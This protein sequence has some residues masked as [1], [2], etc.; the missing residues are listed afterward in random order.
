VGDN[1]KSRKKIIG[2]SIVS[3]LLLSLC[4]VLLLTGNN[5]TVLRIGKY[6][7]ENDKEAS[8]INI[9]NENEIRF[10][11]FDYDYLASQF[12]LEDTEVTGS[13]IKE[14]LQKTLKYSLE[15]DGNMIDICVQVTEYSGA[16]LKYS[17]Y[18]KTIDFLDQ[19]F[20]YSEN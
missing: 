5:D 16:L 10:E 8:C 7:L 13:N 6:Y 12:V 17:P 20:Y 19:T 14:S 3:I 2:I 9:I 4:I 15:K 1:M 11:N 18:K